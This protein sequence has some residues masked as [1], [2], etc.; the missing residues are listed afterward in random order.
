MFDFVQEKKRVVQIVLFL[1]I[2]TFG[3]FL[4]WTRTGNQAGV[5]HCHCE[6]RKNQ[7]AGILTMHCVSSRKECVNRPG[8]TSILPCLKSQKSS[9]LILDSLVR[10]ALIEF[11]GAQ[12]GSDIKR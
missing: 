1:I 9:A 6:W 5:I 12:C 7:P 11:A 4:A 10:P 2:V 3:L 8:V